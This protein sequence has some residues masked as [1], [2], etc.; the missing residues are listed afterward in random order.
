M[1]D[2][3][4]P[5]ELSP[6]G[7][8]GNAGSLALLMCGLAGLSGCDR[9]KNFIDPSGSGYRKEGAPPVD[10]VKT[11]VPASAPSS[12]SPAP[13]PSATTANDAIIREKASGR[14]LTDSDIGTQIPGIDFSIGH[15]DFRLVGGVHRDRSGITTVRDS[16][17]RFWG[18]AIGDLNMDGSDDAVLLLRTDRPEGEVT[19]DLAYL[20]NRDGGLHDVQTVRLPGDLG[21]RDVVI[22]GSEV[23]LTPIQDGP[24]V[25]LGYSG[26]ELVLSKK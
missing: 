11:S 21:F 22:E 8:H 18:K 16:S 3:K 14:F 2:M 10:A 12:P 23:I 15:R 4:I 24:N 9:M 6:F 25:H 5:D 13:A 7:S 17:G 20:A 19:W 1:G 26:G